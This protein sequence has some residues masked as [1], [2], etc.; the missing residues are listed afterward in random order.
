MGDD[1]EK[2]RQK[3]Y[4]IGPLQTEFFGV[5]PP[6]DAESAFMVPL[7]AFQSNLDATIS[8]G[9]VPFRL[10]SHGVVNE[11]YHEL[12]R[13]E[14]VRT[15]VGLGEDVSQETEKEAAETA[16]TKVFK[17]FEDKEILYQHAGNTLK[18]LHQFFREEEDFR[19]SMQELLRQVLVMCWGAFEVLVNDT[20][21]V[22]LNERPKLI[23]AFAEQKPYRELLSNRVLFD[24]LEANSF[25]LSSCMGDLF[26][27][28]VKLD[29]LPK[30]QKAVRIGLNEPSV[31]ILL[32]DDRLWKLG[33]QRHLIVHR[34][35]LVDA[36]YLEH[37]SDRVPIG[38]HLKV[39]AEYV[40]ES[41]LLVRDTG[42]SIHKAA[43]QRLKGTA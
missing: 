18:I 39:G 7:L 33:Q 20:I 29:A 9:T 11:R 31:D 25:N 30:I 16:Q 42:L 6:V 2:K 24:A 35:G 21:R 15:I 27:E 3:T 5:F 40:E 17:E 1:E 8:V 22:L 34:R 19:T 36:D 10:A 13:A 28:V 23:K 12:L 41:L 4:L 32:K 43:E 14:R 38:E 37:T 26:S